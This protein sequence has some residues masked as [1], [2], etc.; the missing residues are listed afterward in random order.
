M[1]LSVLAQTLYLLMPCSG[2]LGFVTAPVFSFIN[3]C[4]PKNIIKLVWLL[5]LSVGLKQLVG[6]LWQKGV[7]MF[8]RS[9]KNCE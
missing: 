9:V 8:S 2:D 5:P 1:D 6:V 7:L 3:I 4:P